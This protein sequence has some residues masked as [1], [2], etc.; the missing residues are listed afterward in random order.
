[1]KANLK[2]S[3]SSEN[4]I[5]KDSF[6]DEDL[7][8]N[9]KNGAVLCPI[10]EEEIQ[11]GKGNI[12]NF[13][14]QHL[15]SP[16]CLREGEKKKRRAKERKSMGSIMS[17]LTQKAPLKGTRTRSN[18]AIIQRIQELE[19]QLPISI[20]NGTISDQMAVFG[21]SPQLI[22]VPDMPSNELWEG[23]LNSV[24]KTGLGWGVPDDWRQVIR[25]GQYGIDGLVAF[26]EY[27]CTVRGV[28]I[29]L[30][31]GKLDGLIKGMELLGNIDH[32]NSTTITTLPATPVVQDDSDND[33]AVEILPGPASYKP[34]A[35]QIIDQSCIGYIPKALI[36][37]APHSIYPFAIH[38]IENIPWGYSYSPN[39]DDGAFRLFSKA[40]KGSRMKKAGGKDPQRAQ[41][42]CEACQSLKENTLLKAVE[43]RMEEGTHEKA[44]YAYHGISGLVQLLRQKNKQ[45]DF[46]RLHGLNQTRKLLVKARALTDHSRFV[47]AV[48]SGS[49]KRVAQVVHVALGQKRGIAGIVHQLRAASEENGEKYKVKSFTEKEMFVATLLWR[50]GGDRVGAIAHKALGLPSVKVLRNSSTIVPIIPSTAQPTINEVKRN[51]MAA[52]E[53]VYEIIHAPNSHI[54][55]AVLMF[56]E[57]ATEKRIRWNHKTNKFLG[58]C[59]EHGQK[60]SLEYTSDKDMEELFGSLDK[61]EIHYAA[62]ATVG[63]LGIL[64]DDNRIYPARPVLVS[65]DCKRE[66]GLEH[67]KVLST[68]I[69]GVNALKDESRLRIVSLAS[70]GE[71]R[72]GSSMIALTF[73]RPLAPGSPIYPHLATLQF[74]NL[75]VGDDDM[76]CDK[77]WKHVFKR[78]RNLLLRGRGIVV[79]GIRITPAMMKTH[80]HSSGLSNEHINA[81]FNPEDQQDVKL[82]F[83]LL[84]DIW[85]L[86]PLMTHTSGDKPENPSLYSPGFIC[87]RAAIQT[88]GRLLFHLVY[89]YLCVDLSLGEQLEHLS[90]AAHLLLTLYR[91]EGNKF[92]PTLLYVDIM[93]MIKNVFFCVAKAKVDTPHGR[94]FLILLGT[95]RL[96]I[97]FGILR[98]MIGNDANVDLLQLC[99]RLGSITEVA[100]ILAKYSEWDRAPRQLVTPT[101]TKDSDEIT[102]ISD[103]LSPKHIRGDLHVSRVS[104]LTSWKRGRVLAECDHPA[105]VS[106]LTAACEDVDILAPKGVALYDSP[107]LDE[108][109]DESL[110]SVA[111]PSTGPAPLANTELEPNACEDDAEMLVDIENEL[112]GSL[113]PENPISINAYE[114]ATPFEQHVTVNGKAMPKSRRLA[115]Y[116]R[117]RKKASSTDRLKR[118]QEIERYHSSH[119]Q[120]ATLGTPIDPS[121]AVVSIHDPIATVLYCDQRVWLCLGEVNS[122][123]VDGQPLYKIPE[124]LLTEKVTTVSFQ[125]LGLR[126]ATTTDDKQGIHDWRT[127]NC[128]ERT[129]EVPGKSI[130][131]VDPVI[132]H[133][134]AGGPFFLFQTPFLVALAASI[135]ER[136]T[137]NELKTVPKIAITT[138]FPYREHT[139]KSCFLCVNNSG[140]DMKDLSTSN[141]SICSNCNP[142]VI[143][144]HSQGQRV[145]EHFGAHILFDETIDRSS[146]ARGAGNVKIDHERSTGCPNNINYSYAVAKVSKDSSPCSNVPIACPVC[147]AKEPAIWRYN[148]RAHFV[149]NHLTSL[150][151]PEYVALWTISNNEIEKMKVIWQ[152]R[153]QSSVKRPR[154][155]DTPKLIASDAHSSTAPPPETVLNSPGDMNL[156]KDHEDLTYESPMGDNGVDHAG[157]PNESNE[158]SMASED[159]E[160][161]LSRVDDGEIKEGS[162]EA[163][164]AMSPNSHVEEVEDS[165]ET[166]SESPDAQTAQTASSKLR[167]V[168]TLPARQVRKQHGLDMDIDATG[169]VLNDCFCGHVVLP[170][171]GGSIQCKKPGCETVWYHVG[172]V[173]VD[174]SDRNWTCAVC[175][176][177]RTKRPRR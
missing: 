6:K 92:I 75:A 104:L 167:L 144:D 98:T 157:I 132:A 124:S 71:T 113:S 52:L 13:K 112:A 58:V 134:Q 108:E 136:L 45:I 42:R 152:T 141:T 69:D 64:C 43:Q 165:V 24:M 35:P 17:Y 57:I 76:I 156:D 14:S 135:F 139:G 28:D 114:D 74:M 26:V 176:E 34:S 49:I 174:S 171:S 81:V 8:R 2:A 82:A 10:C 32:T 107:V 159:V 73:K 29:A 106:D 50:L 37:Q 148:L 172:C 117:Y 100:N 119:Q 95:D 39:R 88:L 55:H 128:F 67:A 78:L 56:D 177:S 5:D 129:F 4:T 127:Y 87:A 109:V 137:Q 168:L 140:K 149:E 60:V 59:R 110:E 33:I 105:C 153:Q 145:L 63:A 70:D 96:E 72:R 9:V 162:N 15:G 62:E 158:I 44:N 102:R 22:D 68:V 94:F 7:L 147:P 47:L 51:A 126:P 54:Q 155:D 16:R 121:A 143:L 173:S 164:V 46:Y 20:P 21:H 89:P 131:P 169:G 90:A 84:H 154:K 79:N 99:E 3:T 97:Q 80:M 18:F 11:M 53:G 123:R 161:V 115:L 77:D 83:D 31:E 160:D 163:V 103:H 61:G 85:S 66:S 138:E 86:P 120:A 23:V 1:M 27:F 133:S 40:C 12:Q 166:L 151:I 91:R 19:A 101:L 25:R 122:I 170:N 93:I 146:K 116:S 30:F 175:R 36:G 125:L 118:V 130:Q 38:D 142:E 41:W 65:G 150:N 111:F 48:A